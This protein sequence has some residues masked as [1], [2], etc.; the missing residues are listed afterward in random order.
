MNQLLINA[1]NV[2]GE[3]IHEDM[4]ANG[5]WEKDRNDG[6]SIALMHSEL[7]EA[8]EAIRHGNEPSEH[9]PDFSGVEE[10]MADTVIRI[11]DYCQGRG[12]NL[13]A[14]I[15]AKCAFNRTR[16]YKHGGKTC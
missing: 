6:E 13:G 7:S 16:G 2:V 14:A 4:K 12:F 5:W 1:I 8:L 9:I 10:E 3:K 15:A 11:M